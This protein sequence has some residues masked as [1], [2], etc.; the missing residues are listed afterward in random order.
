VERSSRRTGTGIGIH[1]DDSLDAGAN[2]RLNGRIVTSKGSGQARELLV[3][4][5]EVIG[6][7][8]PEVSLTRSKQRKRCLMKGIS[9]PKEIPSPTCSS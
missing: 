6:G 9:N 7:C 1:T 4:S 3:E 5:T 8:D 2:V